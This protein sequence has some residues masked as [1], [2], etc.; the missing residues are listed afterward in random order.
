MMELF[1]NKWAAAAIALLSS[2]AA[3]FVQT[4]FILL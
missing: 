3:A 1:L 2:I 4:E